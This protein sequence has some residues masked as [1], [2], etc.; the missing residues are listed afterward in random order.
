MKSRH[1][2]KRVESTSAAVD[3]AVELPNWK[4]QMCVDV[5]AD[6]LHTGV[7]RRVGAEALS[8]FRDEDVKQA[9]AAGQRA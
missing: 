9:V 4:G 3:R 1:T 7:A 5:V 2:P 6:C 8:G